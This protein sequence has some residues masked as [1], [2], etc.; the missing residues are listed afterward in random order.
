LKDWRVELK[1]FTKRVSVE[2]DLISSFA[3]TSEDEVLDWIHHTGLPEL[4]KE[5][6]E[7]LIYRVGDLPGVTIGDT[8]LV[9]GEGLREFKIVDFMMYSPNRPGVLLDSGWSEEVV[10]I[11]KKIS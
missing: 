2:G 9:S 4:R 6:G 8:V 7:N 1:V 3:F 10:K 5:Y 11:Y